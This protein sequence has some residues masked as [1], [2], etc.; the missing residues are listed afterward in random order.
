MPDDSPQIP[1]AKICHFCTNKEDHPALFTQGQFL[2]KYELQFSFYLSKQINEILTNTPVS[3]VVRFKEYLFI[4]DDNE[5]L[6]R[7]YQEEEA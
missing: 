6:K 2:K 1:Q 5:Y 3:N 7:T 4:D